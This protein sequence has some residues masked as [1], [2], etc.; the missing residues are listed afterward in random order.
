MPAGS[1]MASRFFSE[2]LEQTCELAPA[3]HL[4][5][6]DTVGVVSGDPHPGLVGDDP[7]AVEIARL[8]AH[9][10]LLDAFNY[11]NPVIRVDDTVINFELHGLSLP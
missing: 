6:P 11:T 2:L 10:R 4:A 3:Y 9:L 5:Q 8:P 1:G 7:Q